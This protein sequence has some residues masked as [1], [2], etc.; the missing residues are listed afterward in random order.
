M[1]DFYLLTG[2]GF[3]RNWGGWLAS[4]AFE[5][6][7][8]C[9][10]LIDRASIRQLLWQ[11]QGEGG[12]EEV[13][14]VLQ[15]NN[16][17]NDDLATLMAAVQGMFA[18]MNKSIEK[19][20]LGNHFYNI[21]N[22]LLRFKSIFTLNQDIFLET[23]YTKTDYQSISSKRIGYE[24]PGMEIRLP[25]ADPLQPMHTGSWHVINPSYSINPNMQQIYKL[26]G[27]S[28]W[29]GPGPTS[30]IIIG[31]Y[32]SAAIQGDQ[33]FTRYHE[34]FER[35]I[36]SD[37]VKL[38]IMGYGFQDE[39]IN[40]ALHR[41]IQRGLKFFVTDPDG[42]EK[43]KKLNKLKMTDGAIGSSNSGLEID[44]ERALIGASRRQ[45]FELTNPD[46]IENNKLR[47]FFD[48]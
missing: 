9:P 1:T 47:H 20:P 13:I 38:M 46:S 15:Q 44:F 24:F 8:G 29:M 22:F 11:K 36:S 18:I 25:P 41:A 27:S 48:F 23:H 16:N 6:L 10:E 45:M 40:A 5:Y 32:K 4:E 34:D 43:A 7:I 28:N 12:F 17:P 42:A 3:T 31:G 35:S 26:H 19:A 37:K 14:S 33:L 39:H 21:I 30:K 2:A